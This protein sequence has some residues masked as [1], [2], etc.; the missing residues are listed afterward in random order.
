LR[1]AHWVELFTISVFKRSLLSRENMTPHE[2]LEL[3]E[4]IDNRAAYY[5]PAA[6]AIIEAAPGPFVEIFREALNADSSESGATFFAIL[7]HPDTRASLL[8]INPSIVQ[9]AELCRRHT[10]SAGVD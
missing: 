6:V 2:R 7:E 3:L 8:A 10:G 9:A 4:Y 1:E 5:G